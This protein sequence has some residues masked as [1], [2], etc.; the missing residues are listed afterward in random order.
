ME[1][2][3]LNVQ[4]KLKRSE[5]VGNSRKHDQAKTC[6]T[7][8]FVLNKHFRAKHFFLKAQR[9]PRGNRWKQS[10][11]APSLGKKNVLYRIC[12]WKMFENYTKTCLFCR[13]NMRS[14]TVSNRFPLDTFGPSKKKLLCAEMFIQQKNAGWTSFGLIMFPTVSDL[15]RPF[16]FFLNV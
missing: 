8:I 14:P 3:R 15:F 2:V 7:C 6:P 9:C 1:L 10:E 5:K 13:A 16:Q 4:K 12:S 11:I